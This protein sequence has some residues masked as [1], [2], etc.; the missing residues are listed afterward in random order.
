MGPFRKE[1]IATVAGLFIVA[2]TGLGFVSVQ[3]EITAIQNKPTPLPIIKTVIVTPTAT[4]SATPSATLNLKS[5]NGKVVLPTG[6][7]RIGTPA[8]VTKGAK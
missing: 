4:P 1:F 5:V 8:A 7:T 6:L 3:K 2:G